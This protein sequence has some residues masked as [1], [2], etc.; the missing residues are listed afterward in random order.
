M[1]WKIKIAE[2]YGA[3]SPKFV[4]TGSKA[5]EKKHVER[6]NDGNDRLVMSSSFAYM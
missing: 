2:P 3:I 4:Q 6:Q 5:E 1:R